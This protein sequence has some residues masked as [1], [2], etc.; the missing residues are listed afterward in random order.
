MNVAIFVAI[1]SKLEDKMKGCLF[2][3]NAN[4]NSVSFL[5]SKELPDKAQ[6]TKRGK[7]AVQE[8]LE[9]YPPG[10]ERDRMVYGI[11]VEDKEKA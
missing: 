9:E 5:P 8:L 6:L 3:P 7:Q 10:V 4:P 2:M 11:W 1:H